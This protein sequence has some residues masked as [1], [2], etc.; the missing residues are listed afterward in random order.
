M[1]TPTIAPLADRLGDPD[2]TVRLA[3][4]RE[5]AGLSDP[6]TVAALVHASLDPDQDV[7]TT[8]IAYLGYVSGP[9]RAKALLVIVKTI[10]DETDSDCNGSSLRWLGECNG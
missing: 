1:P 5:L 4:V 3:A 2:P 7:A 8:A 10:P 6:T 9:E